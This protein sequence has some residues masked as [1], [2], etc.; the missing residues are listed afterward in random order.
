MREDTQRPDSTNGTASH[1]AAKRHRPNHRSRHRNIHIHQTWLNA[2]LWQTSLRKLQSDFT[3][4]FMNITELITLR[5]WRRTAK[6][7]RGERARQS[8]RAE[9]QRDIRTLARLL[10]RYRPGSSYRFILQTAERTIRD[11]EGLPGPR[12][13][14]DR[15]LEDYSPSPRPPFEITP[16]VFPP[17]DATSL[18][19]VPWSDPSTSLRRYVRR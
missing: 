17:F 14:R 3:K 7:F 8:L 18:L 12:S 6:F 10:L 16:S 1:L 11:L 9:R 2:A 4:E 5:R 15:R 13:T 19:N